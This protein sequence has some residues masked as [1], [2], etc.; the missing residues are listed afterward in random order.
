M[1]TSDKVA[2]ENG[3]KITEVTENN[4]DVKTS[5]IIDSTSKSKDN[6]D[7]QNQSKEEIENDINSCF[8]EYLNIINKKDI[9]K[10]MNLL[11]PNRPDYEDRRLLFNL[12]FNE[13]DISYCL[14]STNELDII[15]D[16]TA[17]LTVDIKVVND[18]RESGDKIVSDKITL[19]TFNDKWKI[20]SEK[21]IN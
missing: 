9:T 16:D 2:V 18:P 21:F 5:N 20:D 7:K 3:T 12:M 11:N 10:V 8:D 6:K 1:F 17:I 4:K 15:N 19:K 13:F 14:I